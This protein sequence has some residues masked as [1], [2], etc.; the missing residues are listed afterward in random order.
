M[1]MDNTKKQEIL[2]LIKNLDDVKLQEILTFSREIAKAEP[3]IIRA[4][5]I[6]DENLPEYKRK[7]F[8]EKAKSFAQAYASRGLTNKK[9]EEKVKSL[10]VLSCHGGD[11]FAPCPY[12]KQSSLYPESFFCTACGCGDKKQTQLVNVKKEDGTEEYSKLDFP[13]VHCPLEMPGFSNYTETDTTQALRNPRKI[14][15]ESAFGADYIKQNST[16]NNGDKNEQNSN[17]DETKQENS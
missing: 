17:N 12:R 10:R 4:K 5:E 1:Q 8:F 2:E 14:F 13:V 16:L 7:S 3:I 6:P 11:E 15:I 9:A